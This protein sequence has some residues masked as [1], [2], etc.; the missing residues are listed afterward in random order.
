L[1]RIVLKKLFLPALCF[2]LL[3]YGL[4]QALYLPFFLDMLPFFSFRDWANFF[5]WINYI[6]V[7]SGLA[8]YKTPA[9]FLLAYGVLRQRPWAYHGILAGLASLPILIL[10]EYLWWGTL[11]LGTGPAFLLLGILALVAWAFTRPWVKVAFGTPRFIFRSGSGAVAA[12]VL[13]LALVP[14]L[15][16]ISLKMMFREHAK[17]SLIAAKKVMGDLPEWLKPVHLMDCMLVVPA[18]GYLMNY[19]RLG[20]SPDPWQ[21]SF[22]G[23]SGLLI[24]SNTFAEE[25]VFSAIPFVR[26]T[27]LE[28]QRFFLTN[29]WNPIVLT[30][31]SMS[32][33]Q[34]PDLQVYEI[35]VPA[36]GGF[37]HLRHIQG[38]GSDRLQGIFTIHNG[39]RT[40]SGMAFL[41]GERDLALAIDGILSTLR[42][43]ERKS[44]SLA[45]QFSLEGE[46]LTKGGNKLD[47][48]VA[49]ANA[50][51][52]MPY[53]PKYRDSLEA[54]LSPE[55]P[56]AEEY[57][58]GAINSGP[59]KVAEK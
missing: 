2:F 8:L 32:Q 38:E 53:S 10:S 51:Y 41:H 39:E 54:T 25:D 19:N 27:R 56:C 11:R 57:D 16:S 58:G 26:G 37:L 5:G 20:F 30:L 35:E 45:V 46:M 14:L 15:T 55:S 49:M 34:L 3:L 9:S 50:Y 31:R 23:S 6:A 21:F 17:P 13:L 33:A 7:F 52:L 40:L 47:A 24:Y 28:K 22:R 59:T 12:L 36:G 43:E 18:D 48:Q 29:G 42:F 1:K 4:L 44:E